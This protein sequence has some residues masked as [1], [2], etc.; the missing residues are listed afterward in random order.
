MNLFG[1]GDMTR[2]MEQKALTQALTM[3]EAIEL[4]KE[5]SC[6]RP[7]RETLEKACGKEGMSRKALEEYLIDL[8]LNSDP[9]MTRDNVRHNVRLWTGDDKLSIK[10]EWAL[11]L[12]LVFG[13]SLEE[14]EIFLARTCQEGLHWRDPRDIAFIFAVQ[15]GLN[16]SETGE[17][18]EELAAAPEGLLTV[19]EQEEMKEIFTEQNSSDVRTLSTKEEL[20]AYLKENQS[21]LGGFH[22][23][24]YDFFRKYLATIGWKKRTRQEEQ[25]LEEK[26]QKSGGAN[27][28]LLYEEEEVTTRDVLD[29][30]MFD[31][32]IPRVRRAVKGQSA[33]PDR[34]LNGLKKEL[35]KGLPE[36]T[37]FSRMVNRKTDIN[38]KVLMLLF[39]ATDGEMPAES[40]EEQLSNEQAY[41]EMIDSWEPEDIVEDRY[42]RMNTMLSQCGFAQIDPRNRFDWICLYCMSIEDAV[43]ID[44]RMQRFLSDMFEVQVDEPLAGYSEE[45]GGEDIFKKI[46]EMKFKD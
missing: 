30:C 23:T 41:E 13:L 3:S 39:L 34:L 25:A 15:N 21:C 19:P 20:T 24:G 9:K 36:E 45:D 10:R 33:E 40:I 12:A 2:L 35:R 22:N 16:L 27:D 46:W 11:R 37:E 43:L 14:T 4:M 44:G 38:R 31:K 26:R 28:H 8:I 32:L 17:L 5:E 1:N 18:L 29:F 6:L 42:E 7:V